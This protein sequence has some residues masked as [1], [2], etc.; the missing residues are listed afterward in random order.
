MYLEDVLGGS[1]QFAQFFGFDLCGDDLPTGCPCWKSFI[2][3][4]LKYS[5][6]AFYLSLNIYTTQKHTRT[7]TTTR[8]HTHTVVLL[9]IS[10]NTYLSKILYLKNQILGIFMIYFYGC[11]LFLFLHFPASQSNALQSQCQKINKCTCIYI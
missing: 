2:W 4:R 8:A 5:L 1:V 6:T 10:T 11:F 9:T 3:F 7:H